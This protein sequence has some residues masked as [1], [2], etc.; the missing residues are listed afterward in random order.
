[1]KNMQKTVGEKIRMYRK[2]RQLTLEEMAAQI[3]KSK[4]I[5]SKYELGESVFDI[6]TMYKM[7]EVLDIDPALLLDPIS[8]IEKNDTERFGVFA[9]NTLYVYMVVRDRNVHLLKGMMTFS[10]DGSGGVTFYMQVPDF[11]H[12]I[13]CKILYTGN[14]VSHPSNIWI[15]LTNQADKT[16]HA[17]FNAAVRMGNK[18]ACTGMAMMTS[19]SSYEPGALKVLFS[20]FPVADEDALI[21]LLIINRDDIRSIRT[22]NILGYKLGSIDEALVKKDTQING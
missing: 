5:L 1:M 18:N 13:D 14:I 11:E 10:G 19:Y 20:K 6:D 4:S 3:N 9:S 15:H 22:T 17:V 16:D 12:Y 7:A 8:S 2:L 21:D